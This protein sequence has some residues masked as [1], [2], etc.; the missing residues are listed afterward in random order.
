M[1]T[2]ADAA[3]GVVSVLLGW[4]DG[5]VVVGGSVASG[6]GIVVEV[7]DGMVAANKVEVSLG[8]LVAVGTGAF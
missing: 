7:A 2:Q 1:F 8:T 5:M 3:D 6:D 4:G